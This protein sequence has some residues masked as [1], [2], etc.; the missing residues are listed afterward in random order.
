MKSILKH[1]GLLA[2]GVGCIVGGI[3]FAPAAPVLGTLGT[4][5]LLA[6]GGTLALAAFSPTIVKNAALDLG[7][8]IPPAPPSA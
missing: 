3:F 1:V 7:M 2:V 8:S 4:K 5:F 6:G